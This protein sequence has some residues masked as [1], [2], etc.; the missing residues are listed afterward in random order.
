MLGCAEGMIRDRVL[1]ERNNK[2]NP[3]DDADIYR[4]FTAMVNA[5]APQ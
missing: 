4:T 1:A 5:L 3:F 2:P